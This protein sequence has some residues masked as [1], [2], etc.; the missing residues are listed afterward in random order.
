[1]DIG[2]TLIIGGGIGG[3]TAGIA[4]RRKD[5]PVEIIERDASWTVYGVGII[6]QLN[7]VRAMDQIGALDAF[8]AKSFGFDKTT[9]FAGPAGHKV[10]EFDTPRLAGPQYPSNVGIRRTDLQTVL[11]D[12]A[13]EVG[14]E[15]RLG[16]AVETMNDDGLGV[17]VTFS[18]GSSGRYDVVVGADGLFSQ[19]RGMIFPDAPKPRYT[20]QWVWRYN[21][22]RPADL[23]GIHVFAGPCNAGL[24][25]MSEDLMYMFL[26]TAEEEGLKVGVEGAAAMMRERIG[27]LAPPQIKNYVDQITD[28]KGVVGRPMEVI[29]IEGEWHK[30]RVVLLGDAL[31][32]ATPHQGQGAG[33]AIEDAL[34]LA[35]EIEGSDDLETAFK[36]YKARRWHRVEQV[37]VTSI[38]IGDAQMGKI[39]PVDVGALTA[40]TLKLV[41]E[42]I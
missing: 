31:H 25:P 18:D 10:A 24:V 9:I 38:K 2:K 39:E 26:V 23:D 17:D 33:M 7:V 19:T 16:L 37:A 8:I 20:G 40:Q 29:L 30:G 1:M 6:Q 5:I 27:H 36:A 13:K 35:D 11:A 42:P 14:V 21:L 41:A 3:L 28:D 22:P 4:M 32:A 15:I 12:K 34:V